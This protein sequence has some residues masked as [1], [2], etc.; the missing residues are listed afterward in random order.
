M[1]LPL[2]RLNGDSAWRFE[3]AG[4]CVVVDPWLTGPEV[5]IAPWF[6]TQWLTRPT[7]TAEDVPAH[8]VVLVSQ[9]Y[10][11]HCHPDTLRSL[12]GTPPVVVVPSAR[13]AIQAA[14]PGRPVHVLPRWGQSALELAGLSWWRLSPPWWRVP[15]YH[16][17]VV[18]DS[19]GRAVVHAPHGLPLPDAERLVGHVDVAV[20]AITRTWYALPWWLG[21]AAQPGAEAAQVVVDLLAPDVALPI[22]EDPKR[23]TGLVRRLER[24]VAAPSEVAGPPWRGDVPT[25]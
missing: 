15:P 6:N 20:L 5:D 21:G 12:P 19:H 10:G 16:A 24:S 25:A 3:L 2:A 14:L 18:A 17:V 1:S 11:D 7:V 23:G 8:D 22:H 13:A 4:T 9:P